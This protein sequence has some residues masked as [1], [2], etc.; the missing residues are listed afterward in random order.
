MRKKQ[1]FAVGTV[2]VLL[3][4]VI[5]GGYISLSM[6]IAGVSKKI[7]TFSSSVQKELE[8]QHE[9]SQ[10]LLSNQQTVTRNLKQA[11]EAL[12]LPAG[13][14]SFPKEEEASGG[15]SDGKGSS[16]DSVFY[17]AIDG[18]AAYYT[19]K[20]LEKVLHGFIE[21]HRQ[22]LQQAGKFD[23][24]VI[25]QG[26]ARYTV[27]TRSYTF[28]T[29]VGKQNG[30]EEKPSI[31]VSAFD[32][33]SK[34]FPLEV[35]NGSAPEDGRPEYELSN[36]TEVQLQDFVSAAT[37][38][39]NSQYADYEKRVR[40]LDEL[41][42]GAEVQR[43]LEK[44]QLQ[45]KKEESGFASISY[46]IRSTKREDT[47]V[48]LGLSLEDG[49]RIGGET[50]KSASELRGSLLKQIETYDNRKP[51]EIRVSQAKE[52][53]RSIARDPAF[54]AYLKQHEL[55]IDTEPREGQDYFYFDLKRKDGS[56]FGSFAVLKKVGEIY[57]AD[58]EDVIISSLKRLSSRS[59]AAPNSAMGEE[60]SA[61]YELPDNIP[62]EYS[63]TLMGGDGVTTILL[64]GTHKNNADTIILA[65]MKKG[66]GIALLSIPRDLYHEGRKFS[67]YYRIYGMDRFRKVV[68]DITGVSID[69]HIEVD[70]YAFID[71]VDILGGIRVKLEESLIDPTYKI[72]DHGEWKTL[73]YPAGEHQLSGIEALRVA[74]SRHTSDDFD[75][76]NRQHLLLQ[77]LREK[78]KRLNA[79]KL[80]EL[81]K[82]FKT[83]TEYIETDFSPYELAQLFLSYRSTPIVSTAGLSTENVLFA[84]YSNLHRQDLTREEVSD[85]FNKGAWILLPKND[86]WSLINWFVRKT[87]EDL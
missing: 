80:D 10:S 68:S 19:Q 76:A 6:R 62:E 81:Y 43:A 22:Q 66:E 36:T 48:T 24:A 33:S 18:I 79:G 75:R 61:E 2:G 51:N 83:L 34:E 21:N 74:R 54:Q 30:K 39:L 64:C 40:R 13:A 73:Y 85:D 12:N 44:K 55:S 72:R 67:S 47:V 37:E 49:Y 58:R 57:L 86:N 9:L 23:A 63:Q 26:S 65:R 45:V 29:I 25:E 87:F 11:R 52:R 50:K 35:K 82:L 17:R 4:A 3:A 78:I 1:L 41:L 53:M 42:D 59:F 46:R 31:S 32:N 16:E 71:I 5:L 15:S 69:G 28:L 14:Y 27:S 60:Q 70:M 7:E 20:E 8:A 84:T 56:R 38:R 77:A